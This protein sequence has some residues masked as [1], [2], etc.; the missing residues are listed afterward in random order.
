MYFHNLE[1]NVVGPVT[2]SAVSLRSVSLK[3]AFCFLSFS[4]QQNRSCTFLEPALIRK[5][6]HFDAVT[7]ADLPT[8]AQLLGLFNKLVI[9]YVI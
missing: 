9:Y 2:G 6:I 1:P 3:I 4:G 8:H 5:T 7:A